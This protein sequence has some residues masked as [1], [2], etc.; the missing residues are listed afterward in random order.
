MPG[1]TGILTADKSDD[2]FFMQV[3]ALKHYDYQIKH[4]RGKDYRSAAIG[5]NFSN[6]DVFSY[7]DRFLLTFFGDIYDHQ[8]ENYHDFYIEFIE[9][10]MRLGSDYLA[11]LNGQFQA[12]LYDV[13]TATLYLMTD[14]A[15][16][17]PLYYYAS[18]GD[19][20]F[21]CEVKA[22][23]TSQKLLREINNQAIAQLFSFGFVG[24]Q[25]TMFSQIKNLG[26]ARVLRFSQNQISIERYYL[27]PYEEEKLLRTHFSRK[28]IDTITEQV[29]AVLDQAVRRQIDDRKIFLPLS[30]GLDSRFVVALA[31]KYLPNNFTT[32]TFGNL[33]N[34][35]ILFAREVANLLGSDHHEFIVD[36]K[37]VWEFGRRFSYLSDGMSLI[38]GPIQA[39]QAIEALRGENQVMLAAQA[40]D[41]M[42]GSTLGNNNVKRLIAVKEVNDNTISVF[43]NLFM[44]IS[45]NERR[46]LF[47]PAFLEKCQFGHSLF[48]DYIEI[49]KKTHPFYLYQLLLYFEYCRRGVFGG[50][51]MNNF[52]FDV[53]MPSFD[54]NVLEYVINLPLS[55]RDNQ[56]IYRRTFIK[57]FPDLAR[58]RRN[59]T[60]LPISSPEFFHKFKKKE[61]KVVQHLKKT[62]LAPAINLLKRYQESPY[63][64]YK[65]WFNGQLNEQLREVLFDSR[66]LQRP[67]YKKNGI[68][69]LYRLHQTNQA[70][71]SSILWQVINLEYFFRTFV[72]VQG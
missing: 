44:R 23:I 7:Q 51:L 61:R 3:A 57:Y 69:Q 50:N 12:A 21:A 14:L 56:F 29:Y 30:G 6:F 13:A 18:N 70:D 17:R 34:T 45:E 55:L 54:K 40:A 28:E 49:G 47:E 4:L 10:F 5:L 42:W 16:T 8:F 59:D 31:Q 15:G 2:L 37:A 38:N 62:K 63:V 20:A 9:N 35:D 36:P 27:L 26:P 52:F 65:K 68:E 58:I 25:N 46:L 71:Y 48:D 22:L 41:A 66:T 1:I 64:D 67:F 33:Q 11:K 39:A 53:R 32:Y 43:D 24:F 60:N 72:D 19:F